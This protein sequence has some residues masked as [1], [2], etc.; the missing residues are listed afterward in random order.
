MLSSWVWEQVDLFRVCT[1][2]F[3]VSAV[4]G[5][6]GWLKVRGILRIGDTRKMN[7][8]AVLA[9]GVVWFS[10]GEPLRD[11]VSGH[12]AVLI[13]FGLL[14]LVCRWHEWGWFRYAF[15]GY[16]RESDRPHDAF[17]VWF[18]WLVSICGLELVDLIFGSVDLTR[19]AALV[20]GLADAVGEPIGSR[21]GKHRYS[22]RDV[23]AATTHERSW[24]GSFAVAL[25]TSMVVYL[26]F[27][28]TLC[29]GWG[30][31]VATLILFR[32]PLAIAT[33]LLVS[34]VEACTPHGLDN[35][36][37]PISAAVLV[38]GLPLLVM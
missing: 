29:A 15:S 10:S 13:L 19:C 31:P 25:M 8:A 36:T 7:H 11:R 3:F 4:W 24:E 2:V 38:R 34:F 27:S 9:G 37:I 21:F 12:V 6:A 18:S 33:G 32:L 20:L 16:A 17:H 35:L 5:F 22:V 30:L 14:L 23:L 26:S 28:P 1:F